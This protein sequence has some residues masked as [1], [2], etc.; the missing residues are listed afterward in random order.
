[1][2]LPNEVKY[3][4]EKLNKAGFSA[5]V[6]GGAV[7]D[8]LRGQMPHDYDLCTSATPQQMK[9]VFNLERI[10][11]TGISH[12]TITVLINDKPL[13]ITT[14]R[15]E[16]NYTDCRRP[17][18]ISFVKTIDEDLSRR[19]FT[20][21]AIAY[22]P[23]D[24][25]IDLFNGRSDLENNVLK[26]VGD[27]DK[28]FSE[29]A[30]RIL[31]ALR[32]VSEYG[33]KIEPK[34]KNALKER[35]N[36]LLN[37]SV[38]RISVELMRI[39]C[40]RY[41]GRVLREFTDV[42]GVVLP[43][44]LPMKG[45]DQKNQYHI[46][47]VLEHSIRAVEQVKAEPALRFAALYHDTGKPDCMSIDENG[48]GHF[49]SHPKISKKYA[50][51]RTEKLKLSN[52]LS[53]EIIFLVEHHDNFIKDEP[54]IIRKKLAK[55]GE[56]RFRNLIR[57]Q[58]ADCIARGTHEEYLTYFIRLEKLVNEVINEK[59][60]LTVKSLAVNGYDLINLGFKGKQIGDILNKMLGFVIENPQDNR[61]EILLKLVKEGK[62]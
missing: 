25:F 55:F 14:F 23:Y 20:V 1:M 29:D 24:G 2:Y 36:L 12:G 60:C 56:Q 32:M 26:A 6:V 43:E 47:D 15:T 58:K 44:I 17:D 7:R 45:L 4:L 8:A 35:A 53:D 46:Y 27:A 41:V 16:S 34:T 50:E 28:R 38:E 19:D 31:R 49:Y 62:I 57:L 9:D 10:I 5:Y 3:T 11:E 39:L 13:E 54:H 33:F 37:I 48:I 40:G 22:S 21:N 18:S 30:L 59:P 61:K 42:F 51:L 52:A